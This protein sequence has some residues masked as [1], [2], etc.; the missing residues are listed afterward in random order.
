MIVPKRVEW[1]MEISLPD[2]I[3]N[4]DFTPSSLKSNPKI[5]FIISTCDRKIPYIHKMLAT[6]FMSGFPEIYNIKLLVSGEDTGYLDCYKHLPNAKISKYNAT[7]WDNVKLLPAKFKAS[8]NYLKCLEISEQENSLIFE[9]DVVFQHNWLKKFFKCIEM[10]EIDGYEK[11]MMTLF[12][13]D[14]YRT[15]KYYSKV[16]RITWSGTQAVYYP[17]KTLETIIPFV[18]Q[19]TDMVAKTQIETSD[20]PYLNAY[21][22]LIKECAILE[23]IDILAPCESLVQHIGFKTVGGTGQNIMKS[24]IF[25]NNN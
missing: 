7:E 24:P 15:T 19:I 6:M 22:M 23:N 18:K 20:P 21:D 3:E 2:S 14:N 17:K 8:Y 9:D 25:Y 13:K 10:A 16:P 12:C 1:K 5:N 4:A 11:Y